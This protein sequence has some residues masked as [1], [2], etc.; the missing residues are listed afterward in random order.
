MD[1][2]LD[3][4][5]NKHSDK[6]LYNLGKKYNNSLLALKKRNRINMD[7]V[8]I[9]WTCKDE[10]GNVIGVVVRV[11]PKKWKA[12]KDNLYF[13]FPAPA[14]S[15]FAKDVLSDSIM[16]DIVNSCDP[17]L[18]IDMERDLDIAKLKLKLKLSQLGWE[19]GDVTG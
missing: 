9:A 17:S 3:K 16:D 8:E 13:C 15:S 12:L 1:G 5:I 18:G 11:D 4:Y 7:K 6:K 2:S 19:I 14:G 10:A